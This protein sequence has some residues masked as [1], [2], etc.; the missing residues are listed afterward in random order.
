LIVKYD[1]VGNQVWTAQSTNA[2]AGPGGFGFDASTG[3]YFARFT[4][5]NL[6]I[7]H[8]DANGNMLSWHSNS[9]DFSSVTQATVDSAGNVILSGTSAIASSP[10]NITAAKYDSNASLLWES[11]YKGLDTYATNE[12]IPLA[13]DKNGDVFVAGLSNGTDATEVVIVKYDPNG[14]LL[15]ASRY[16]TDDYGEYPS[17]ALDGSGNVFLETP[18]FKTLKFGSNGDLL[19]TAHYVPPEGTVFGDRTVVA[20]EAGNFYL[21]CSLAMMQPPIWQDL[22]T[23]KFNTNGDT[24]WAA[25]YGQGSYYGISPQGIAV[26]TL[27][28]V[29]VTGTSDWSTQ[30][31]LKYTQTPASGFPAII[32]EPQSLTATALTTVSF[33]VS[34]SGASPLQYQWNYNDQ[35][36]PGAT[37]ATLVLTNYPQTAVGDYSVLVSNSIGAVESRPATLTL[38]IPPTIDQQPGS[39]SG[40][41][42]DYL[43]LQARIHGYPSP[44][45]QWQFNGTNIS[46]GTTIPTPGFRP[47]SMDCSFA[48]SNAQP[49]NAGNYRLIITNQFGSTTSAVAQVIISR[50][51]RSTWTSSFDGPVPSRVYYQMAMAVDG[52]GNVIVGDEAKNPVNSNSYYFIV[53]FDPNGNQLWSTNFAGSGTN[54]VAGDMTVDDSG[55]IYVTATSENQDGTD[56]SAAVKY[57]ADG[58]QLWVT[59]FQDTNNPVDLAWKIAVDKAENVYIAGAA[60]DPAYDSRY[61]AAKFDPTGREAWRVFAAPQEFFPGEFPSVPTGIEVNSNGEVFVSGTLGTIKYDALGNELWN[62]GVFGVSE[63]MDGAG[64][65]YVF[66]GGNFVVSK[67]NTGGDRLWST[68]YAGPA[69][70][71]GIFLALGSDGSTYVTGDSGQ[72]NSDFLTVKFDPNGQ[73]LWAARFHKEYPGTTAGLVVDGAGNAYVTGTAGG[74][75]TVKYDSY[76]NQLW[77]ADYNTPAGIIEGSALALDA[78]TNLLVAGIT[79]LDPGISLQYTIINYA[80]DAVPGLPTITTPP[81]S[82]SVF[83]G[84]N[85]VFNVFA[86]GGPFNYQWRFFGTNLPAATNSTLVLTNVQ[87]LNGGDYS[88]LVANGTDFTIS[89]EARLTLFTQLLSPA[90]TAGGQFNFTLV[91]EANRL[92]DLQQSSNLLN[93][94]SVTNFS[95]T[96]GFVPFNVPFTNSGGIFYRAEKI[97]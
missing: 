92:Y 87:P 25:Q 48:V 40:A 67:Y 17:L 89:P 95:N 79:I 14:N 78:H 13:V 86:T 43:M 60:Y 31:A 81:Q 6:L 45:F 35:V 58:N 15:W 93:W 57:D 74:I 1:S 37:N 20:D 28:N 91:G 51:T 42:G 76:G 55:N 24:V 23:V 12:P 88:V 62:S 77:V 41:I 59:L 50:Q 44:G 21:L 85:G 63:K 68:F 9:V 8:F 34:A 72:F 32:Q 64:N 97:P 80:Q 46:G 7:E 75:A 16:L 82:Q 94:I 73:F 49:S 56:V 90:A 69:G 4:S 83:A 30:I 53:K 70:Y 38:G 22:L 52:A 10:D 47:N 26:D 18:G 27:G 3:S 96:N 54:V 33:S 2:A 5:Q 36:I 66:E 61:F 65:I 29:F 39:I 71:F 11:R 19:W 84:S